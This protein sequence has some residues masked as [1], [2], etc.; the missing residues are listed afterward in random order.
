M[1]T[2]ILEAYNENNKVIHYYGTYAVKLALLAYLFR[3][4]FWIFGLKSKTITIIVFMHILA[5]CLTIYSYRL[6]W[7]ASWLT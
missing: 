6:S 7:L 1:Y 4:N 5:M 3:Y 2:K